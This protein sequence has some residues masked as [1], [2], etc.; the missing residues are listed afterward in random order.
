MI[1]LYI[2]TMETYCVT[3]R[4]IPN[5]KILVLE[6][7]NKIDQYFYQITL[8]LVRKSESVLK[9]KKRVDY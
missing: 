3:C 6:E 1:L 7:Q 9:I 8:F 2:K 4:K 5:I